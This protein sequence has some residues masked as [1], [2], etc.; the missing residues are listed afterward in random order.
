[1]PDRVIRPARPTDSAAVNNLLAQLGYPQDDLAATA[2]RIRFWADDP[3]SAAFVADAN[4]NLLGLVAVHAEPFFQLPGFS[5]RI[6]A[7]VVSEH[8]RRQGVAGELMT[9]AESFAVRHGCVRF[10]VTSADH[11]AE[12][13]EFYQRRGYVNQA[14]RSSRFILSAG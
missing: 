1:M 8:A 13:H 9:A 10:E 12:A 2:A 3:T 14:G 5:G 11:R 7:L 4:G 6:V